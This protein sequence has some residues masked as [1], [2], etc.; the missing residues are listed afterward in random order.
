MKRKI[1]YSIIAGLILIGTGCSKNFLNVEVQGQSTPSNDPQLAINLVNGVYSSLIYIDPGGGWNTDTHG[2]SFVA[3]TNIM[4]DDADKGSVI[5]DQ[6]EILD[7][8]NFTETSA[9]TF[10]A[11][12][13]NGYYAGISRANNALAALTSAPLDTATKI[14]L[15]AEVRF[16]RG[17]YYFNLV[18]FFGGVPIILTVPT[19]PRQ[20][21][22]DP[23]FVTRASDSDVYNKAI[24][25]DLQFAMTHLPLKSA[26]AVGRITQ[27][28]ATT[29][30]A[31]VYLYEKNWQQ[32]LTL[33]QDVISSGQYQLVP[34]YSTLWRQV[35]DNDAESIFEVETGGYGNTDAGIP[36]YS[37]LQGPRNSG[38]V[39]N[40]PD[41]NDPTGDLGWGFCT[42]SISLVNAYEPGDLRKAAT[43][44]TINPNPLAPSGD[45]LWDGFVI[46]NIHGT[47]SPYYNYK[48]YHSERKDGIETFYGNRD[49][50]IKNVHLLRY[51]EVLLIHAEAANELTQTGLAISDLNQVRNRAGLPSTTASS[52]SD[53][54]TAIWN[55]RRVELAMEHD[56]FFDIV[57]QG[58]AAQVMQGVGKMFAAGKNEL[59]PIPATQIALSGG[60]LIQNPGY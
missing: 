58:R 19:G 44:I 2:I 7:L 1:T 31:K 55:E 13:W 4:S 22:S 5:T 56:R 43:I 21:V 47:Q 42:P 50:K 8:D 29:L 34:D 12:L 9:N 20:A 17:Y 14:E 30:L 28:A 40:N 51:A 48:A 59:L 36:L 10:V 16:I 33:T 38:G 52:V 15:Q 24:I 25:P 49:R 35:G 6:P 54:R 3:A 45:T 60:K 53:L 11:A 32:A 37:E 18:R 26:Q 57:R 41:F 27:G 39:W 23:S 46:P